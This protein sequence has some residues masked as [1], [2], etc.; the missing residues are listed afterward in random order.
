MRFSRKK[1]A[2]DLLTLAVVYRV[3]G[4][5][6]NVRERPRTDLGR[7]RRRDIVVVLLL[8]RLLGFGPG[9]A[10]W[11]GCEARGPIERLAGLG[12]VGTQI[13]KGTRYMT[14]QPSKS[15]FFAMRLAALA[16]SL[17]PACSAER[18][19]QTVANDDALYVLSTRLWAPGEKIPVCF[20]DPGNVTDT[21]DREAFKRAA[22]SWAAYGNI[23]FSGWGNCPASGFVGI[24][25][26]PHNGNTGWNVSHLGKPTAGFNTFNAGLPT[27]LVNTLQRCEG[28]AVPDRGE[29]ISLYSRHEWGHVLGFSHDQNRPDD[30]CTQQVQGSNGDWLL[31]PP[32]VDSVMSYCSSMRKLSPGDTWGVARVYGLA[33]ALQSTVM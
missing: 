1:V 2:V 11:L 4:V 28:G 33:P 25:V 29:C 8:C 21:S 13:K 7:S 16:V 22:L 18:A 3:G 27:D 15:G 32:D 30:S 20:D 23:G 19:E 5:S 9:F 17:L 10:S 24:E 26:V 6:V 31:G 14:R 12:F